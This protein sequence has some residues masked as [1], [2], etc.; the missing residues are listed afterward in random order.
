MFLLHWPSVSLM[1]AQVSSMLA[2]GLTFAFVI[3]FSHHYMDVEPIL[4]VYW[5]T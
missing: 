1:L 5:Y 4:D 3:T 2:F